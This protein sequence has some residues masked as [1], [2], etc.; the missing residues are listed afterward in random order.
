MLSEQSISKFQ[1][2]Y[3]VR[4]GQEISREEALEKGTKLLR[5]VELV[6]R[7]MTETEY[8]KVLNHRR[9]TADKT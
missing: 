5:M 4:F 6:Y 1:S 9:E 2:L 8:Q 7:P 3:C